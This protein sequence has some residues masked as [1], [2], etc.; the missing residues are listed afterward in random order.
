[1]PAGAESSI[2]GYPT[3][4]GVIVAHPDDE[5]MWAGGAI[6]MHPTWRWDIHAL[7]RGSD[8]DR[9]PRFRQALARLGAS[10]RIADLED[11]PDQIPLPDALVEQQVLSLV[12]GSRFD[13]LVTHSP[14]GEYTTHRRHIETSNAVAVLWRSGRIET[15]ELWFFAY[16]DGGGAHPPRALA[17]AHHRTELPRQIWQEKYAI[18]REVYGF[19]ADSWEARTTPKTEAFWRLTSPDQLAEWMR[20][21]SRR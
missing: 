14:N 1:M 21:R 9:A 18:I 17:D 20:G 7:C 13:V 10:G 19:A 16:E 11:G 2:P 12:G 8:P 3:V 15:G 4:A 5:T 6:L